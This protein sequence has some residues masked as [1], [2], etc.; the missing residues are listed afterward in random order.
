MRGLAALGGR[1]RDLVQDDHVG[2]LDLLDQQV[3]ERSL[4]FRA[5]DLAAIAQEVAAGIVRQ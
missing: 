2:E 1:G 4:V 5:R 3:D